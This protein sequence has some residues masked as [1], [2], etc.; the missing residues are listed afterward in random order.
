[1]QPGTVIMM[2][3]ILSIVWGGFAGLLIY[4]MR[5][6][7]RRSAEGQVEGRTGSVDGGDG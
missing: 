2:I 1:M 5:I 7:R 6:E 3:V 4:S